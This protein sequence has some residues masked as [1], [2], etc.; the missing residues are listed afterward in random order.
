MTAQNK[1]LDPLTY[2]DTPAAMYLV[3]ALNQVNSSHLNRS[4]GKRISTTATSVNELAKSYE[5]G[6]LSAKTYA[7]T[8]RLM[9]E[10]VS[11][12]FIE[13]FDIDVSLVDHLRRN[14]QIGA[15]KRGIRHAFIACK[16]DRVM[17]APERNSSFISPNGDGTNSVYFTD[18]QSGKLYRA[19]VSVIDIDGNTFNQNR[20]I[21]YD[22][23]QQIDSAL[24]H[25]R[26][27]MRNARRKKGKYAF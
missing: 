20:K 24:L 10:E 7:N 25:R 3:R 2:G 26:S 21:S 17:A 9:R 5:A 23:T 6:F 19:G 13:S 1:N 8:L 12:S 18:E 27:D 11:N 4:V 16:A 22:A 15:I 14:V